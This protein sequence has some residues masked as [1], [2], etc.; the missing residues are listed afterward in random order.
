MF[1]TFSEGP[2]VVIVTQIPLIG[3]EDGFA[4]TP[5]LHPALFDHVVQGCARTFMGFVV[6]AFRGGAAFMPVASAAN[7]TR[8]TTA[9]HGA[10]ATRFVRHW[11]S[12][13]PSSV[14]YTRIPSGVHQRRRPARLRVLRIRL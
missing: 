8:S 3:G 1:R 10:G 7:N 6:A 2:V 4:A 5:A 11:P 12:A 13:E 14:G 9:R